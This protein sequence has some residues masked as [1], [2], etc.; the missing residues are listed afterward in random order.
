MEHIVIVKALLNVR[1]ICLFAN[2]EKNNK[3]HS[4]GKVL[5][6]NIKIV[7][8]DKIDTLTQKYITLSFLAC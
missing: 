8:R 7:E 6:L 3:Y 1:T 5:K 4:V 2:E